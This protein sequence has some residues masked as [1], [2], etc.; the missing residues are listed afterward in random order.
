MRRSVIPSKRSSKI[1]AADAIEK[2]ERA[3]RPRKRRFF[4]GIAIAEK[5]E[6][7]R[8]LFISSFYRE[9]ARASRRGWRRDFIG[10][11]IELSLT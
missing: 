4:L 9:R 1:T 10:Y 7:R 6:Q 3:T 11:S 5:D 2:R 8:E